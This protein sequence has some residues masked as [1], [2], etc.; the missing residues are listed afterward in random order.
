MTAAIAAPTVNTTQNNAKMENGIMG[1]TTA[2]SFPSL[3]VWHVA[4]QPLPELSVTLRPAECYGSATRRPAEMC[5]G[6][7]MTDPPQRTDLRC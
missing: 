6:R 7:N 2:I 5:S 3:A 4:S 1:F